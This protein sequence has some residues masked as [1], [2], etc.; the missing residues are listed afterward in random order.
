[1]NFHY[2]SHAKRRSKNSRIELS[3]IYFASDHPQ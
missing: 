1:M 3:K 2:N